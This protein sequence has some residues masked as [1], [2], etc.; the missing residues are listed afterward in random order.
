LQVS[1]SPSPISAAALLQSS[2]LVVLA[3]ALSH[4]NS[5]PRGGN[6][7]SLSTLA[8]LLAFT[9]AS[10]YAISSPGVY[11]IEIAIEIDQ[12]VVESLTVRYPKSNNATVYNFTYSM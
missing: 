5:S 7:F 10:I 3:L 12:A 9:V 6:I 8:L 2:L 4:F 11:S 1:S